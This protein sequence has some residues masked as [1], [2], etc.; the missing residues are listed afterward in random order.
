MKAIAVAVAMIVAASAAHAGGPSSNY[1]YD[2]NRVLTQHRHHN[3]NAEAAL[4]GGLIVGTVIAFQNAQ[5]PQVVYQQPQVIVQQPVYQQPQVIY[6]QRARCLCIRSV[7]CLLL[8]T[9]SMTS[10]VVGLVACVKKPLTGRQLPAIIHT[11]TTH[12]GP[13][14]DRTRQHRIHP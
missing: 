3:G 7:T 8:V 10:L 1:H 5:Q 14:D 9:L 2:S 11:S 6:Q 4:I 12:L 13:Q